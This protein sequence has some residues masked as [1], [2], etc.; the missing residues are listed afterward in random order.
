[1]GVAPAGT[2]RLKRAAAEKAVETL[3]N[4]MVVGLGTGSTAALAIE[5]IGRRVAAEGLEIVG[6]PTSEATASQAHRLG[7]TLG[8]PAVRDRIDVTI[9]GADS[10]ELETL[11][12]I[13]GLGGALLR[14]K[15]V[16]CASDRMIAIVDE[17]KI[18]A[19]FDGRPVPV[20][21]VRFGWE[22]TQRRLA[23]L[24]GRPVLR[25][26][27]GG[28]PRVT[29]GGN[30][31]L[32]CAFTGIDDWAAL[33]AR[34]KGIVGVVETGLFIDIATEVIVASSDGVRVH[35]RR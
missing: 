21:I 19:S 11:A 32:D 13:K 5:A 16:A 15:I 6:I 29:D 22:A 2:D 10:V 18:V 24:G 35:R 25:L 17:S 3:R 20:E 1:M 9:D 30:A 27:A 26:G 7:I 33:H 14:E 12:L 31:I 34:L 8:D 23:A 28:M 4:G